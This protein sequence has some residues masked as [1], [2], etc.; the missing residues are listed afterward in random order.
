MDAISPQKAGVASVANVERSRAYF[1]ICVFCFLYESTFHAGNPGKNLNTVDSHTF[2]DI[3]KQLHNTSQGVSS[4]RAGGTRTG[5]KHDYFLCFTCIYST[6]YNL[7]SCAGFG[8][9]LYCQNKP[10]TS[11]VETAVASPSSSGG[12]ADAAG[13]AGKEKT[14]KKTPQPQVS[15]DLGKGPSL[16]LTFFTAITDNNKIAFQASTTRF[17]TRVVGLCEG[18]G[19]KGLLGLEWVDRWVV[20]K[21][22]ANNDS[23]AAEEWSTRFL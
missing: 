8:S 2:Y 17:R 15:D 11:N 10:S 20:H 3:N 14:D 9:A 19:I 22:G 5:I 16:L 18:R 4:S 12:D 21:A 23:G 7:L 13:D 1:F 6:K